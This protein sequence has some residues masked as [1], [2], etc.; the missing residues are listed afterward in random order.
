MIKFLKK[1][2]GAVKSAWVKTKEVFSKLWD[3]SDLFRELVGTT[4]AAAVVIGSVLLIACIA[5]AAIPKPTA[6]TSTYTPW[7]DLQELDHA[8]DMLKYAH[9]DVDFWK[10]EVDSLQKTVWDNQTAAAVDYIKTNNLV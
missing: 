3:G 2:A 7:T 5:S 10:E 9:D 1:A 8:K 6:S 4:A